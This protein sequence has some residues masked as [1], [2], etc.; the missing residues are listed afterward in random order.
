MH[1]FVHM[2]GCYVI[3]CTCPCFDLQAALTLKFIGKSSVQS[4]M[5]CSLYNL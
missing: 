1:V 4:S 5:L 2:Y 3:T